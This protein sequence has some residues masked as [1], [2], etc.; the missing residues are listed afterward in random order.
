M[1]AALAITSTVGYGTLYYA[2]PVLLNPMA[3]SLDASTTAVTG[4]LTASRM[5]SGRWRN[6]LRR[7]QK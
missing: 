6:A 3:D 4:A 5:P 1:V 7:E 2:Y